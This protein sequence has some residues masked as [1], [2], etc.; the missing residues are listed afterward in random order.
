MHGLNHVHRRGAIY[1]WRRR[2]PKSLGEN[3]YLQ[4]SLRTS[5]FF[6]ANRLGAL[7]NEKFMAFLPWVKSERISTAEAQRFLTAEVANALRQ[8]E[9][10][11]F[12]EPD[13]TSPEQ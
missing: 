8:I 3:R 9:E 10:D 1:V 11:R 7:V 5:D 13:A 6:S 2:L 12:L 4:V